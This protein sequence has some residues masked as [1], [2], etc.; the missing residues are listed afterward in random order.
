M[1]FYHCIVDL[2]FLYTT[3]TLNTNAP[4]RNPSLEEIP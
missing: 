1:S 4:L 2:K 3:D